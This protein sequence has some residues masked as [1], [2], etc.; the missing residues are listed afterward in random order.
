MNR[1]HIFCL[2]IAKTRSAE[3]NDFKWIFRFFFS[4]SF[5][6]SIWWCNFWFSVGSTVGLEWNV[7]VYE[8]VSGSICLYFS[9]SE[10]LVCLRV[11]LCAPMQSH[12]RV[13]V[14][15]RYAWSVEFVVQWLWYGIFGCVIS[16]SL[17]ATLL[18]IVVWFLSYFSDFRF[19]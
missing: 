8:I 10:H 6:L 7:W 19:A 18:A 16:D 12:V 2:I 1:Y 3:L 13:R 14:Y 15:K 5:S 17:F 4:L 9:F 11:S